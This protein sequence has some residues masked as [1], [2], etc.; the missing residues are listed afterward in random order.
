MM[1]LENILTIILSFLLGSG[2]TCWVAKAILEKIVR[3]SLAKELK[4][5]KERFDKLEQKSISDDEKIIN[6]INDIKKNYVT[7]NFC[8]LQIENTNRIHSSIDN[9][10]NT[11]INHLIKQGIND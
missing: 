10:L 5:I 1:N 3:E 7:C 11:I 6:E 8:N 9:K 2:L 4:E